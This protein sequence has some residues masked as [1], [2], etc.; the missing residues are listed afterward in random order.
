MEDYAWVIDYL[1][2]GKATDAMREPI[3]QLIGHQFF[4]LLEAKVKRD[5]TVT[6]GQKV[7][8]GKGERDVIGRIKGRIS[9][10]ELTDTAKE[11]LPEVLKHL[12]KERE[13]FFVAFLNKAG[14][15]SVRVHQLELLPGIGKKHLKDILEERE[16]KPFESFE[17][18][19]QRMKSFPD[20]TSIFV[21]RII[22]ELKGKEKHMFF[23]KRRR[24]GP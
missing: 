2:F 11:N 23:V 5:A 12:V 21:Q 18:I 15:L 24:M 7:Y 17:D 4:T 20:P 9:Y 16:K 6:I 22:D 1:P 8:V 19:K 10:E 13:M 14:P 3:V